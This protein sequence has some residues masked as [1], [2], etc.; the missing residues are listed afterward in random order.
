VG[1]FVSAMN[2]VTPVEDS[3]KLSAAM[4]GGA[5]SRYDGR[6]FGEEEDGDAAARGGC[7]RRCWRW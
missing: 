5:P 2:S 7:S 6:G 1:S 3:S 4:E